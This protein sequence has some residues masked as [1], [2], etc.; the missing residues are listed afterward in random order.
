MKATVLTVFGLLVIA[1]CAA[2]LA[3]AW[4]PALAPITPAA[5]AALAAPGDAAAVADGARLVA[6]GGCA[7]CH[8]ASDSKPFAGGLPLKTPFGVIYTTNITPDAATG[9][10]RWSLEAFRRAL[11]RGVARDGHLLYPAFPYTHYT[12]MTDEDIASVYTYL[13]ARRPINAATPANHLIWPLN[14]RPL[15][16]GWNLLFLHAGPLPPKA[17]PHLQ[18]V[19]A[20]T[21]ATTDATASAADSAAQWQRGR[22]LVEGLGHC[23]A[24]HTP[25]DKLG[26][27]QR[28]KAFAGGLIDGWHAPAL[29]AL[30]HGP[31]PWTRAQ[32]VAYLSTGLASEH[33]AAA[34]P[35]LPVTRGLARASAQDV[36]AVATYLLA[37]QPRAGAE[38][39]AAAAAVAAPPD[40]ALAARVQHGALLFS[41][42]C[43]ECHA[44]HAPMT[45]IGGRPSLAQ[46]TAV[47]ADSARNAI[48]LML[49]GIAWHGADTAHFMPPFA[50]TFTDTQIADLALYM[51]AQFT[52]RPAWPV[53]GL[54]GTVA[55]LRKGNN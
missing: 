45:T 25:L 40:A 32:L 24:C 10:G 47:N 34:G 17:A 1:C 23:A 31:R 36:E 33:G 39:P 2:G 35:M 50:A 6:V 12:R 41:A 28:G 49:G 13:M 16:A 14:F 51:R 52:Q 30:A 42:A 22:Y 5:A 55:K 43:A 7:S 46:S 11:R 4:E 8:T 19:D 37:L 26:A 54:D 44:A 9:I 29:D 3:Q 53:S 18:A 48:N 21:D 38:Q 20:T 27:E 15:L